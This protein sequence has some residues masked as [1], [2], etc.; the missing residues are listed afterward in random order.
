MPIE[1]HINNTMAYNGILNYKE[2]MFKYL[3]ENIFT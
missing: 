3:T 2:M 1:M